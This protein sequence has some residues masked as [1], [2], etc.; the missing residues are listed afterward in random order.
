MK[1]KKQKQ[2][3]NAELQPNMIYYTGTLK[4]FYLMDWRHTHTFT[5]NP[6]EMEVA[7]SLWSSP[8]FVTATPSPSGV[9]RELV[10]R[11]ARVVHP[12]AR[13]GFWGNGRGFRRYL[14]ARSRDSRA[15]ARIKMEKEGRLAGATPRRP[16][17]QPRPE[18]DSSSIRQEAASASKPPR[19]SLL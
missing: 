19:P 14:P 18:R 10:P 6:K 12:T 13:T 11:V 4:Q 17:N 2:G 3:H 7:T 1:A 16:T 8:S 15:R 5:Q 9:V